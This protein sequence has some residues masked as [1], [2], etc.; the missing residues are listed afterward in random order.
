MATTPSGAVPTPPEL[1]S[2]SPRRSI[3]LVALVG[4]LGFALLLLHIWRYPVVGVSTVDP[5]Q[6]SLPLASKL[7]AMLRSLSWLGL[8][9]LSVLCLGALFERWLPCNRFDT[10]E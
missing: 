3:A 1:P 9:N 5:A 7:L 8:I 10:G 6:F 2:H 4:V